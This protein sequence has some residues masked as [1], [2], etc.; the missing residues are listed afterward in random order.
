MMEANW[1]FRRGD[2]Y[3]ADLDPVIGSEQ[4][5]VRPV[6]V[7]QNDHGN[8]YCPTLIVLPITSRLKKLKQPTHYYL[9]CAKGLDAP[10]M[11]VAEQ[12]KTICKSRVIRY[13][14]KLS[15]EQMVG[16]NEAMRCSMDL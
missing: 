9:P 8:Y 16:V 5:G 6:V 10:S 12:P 11:V 4:G 7:V 15:P 2:I 14:G 1:V 13:L 3:R